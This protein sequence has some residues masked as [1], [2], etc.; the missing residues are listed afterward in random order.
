M[1]IHH[2]NCSTLCPLGGHFTDRISPG[3][4]AAH[5]VCHC[6]LIET[7]DGLVL[8]DTGLGIHDVAAPEERINPFLRAIL[9]PKLDVNETAIAQ[10]RA[11]GFNPQNVKHIILT[12]L[13]FDHSG[14]IEDFPDAQIHVLET[15]LRA[16]NDPK[17]IKARIRYQASR[18]AKIKNWNTYYAEGEKWFGFEAVRQLKGIPPEIIMIP[19]CGHSEGHA[20]VA[21]NTDKGW[22]LHA[23]DAYFFRGEI[24]HDYSCPSGLRGYQ[25]LIEANHKMRIL[26][27]IKL[28]D[29]AHDHHSEVRIFSSHDSVEFADLKNEP[30]RLLAG[31]PETFGNVLWMRQPTPERRPFH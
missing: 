20:G 13:D 28:R 2:L 17:G 6:L 7:S 31:S 27:L 19:L 9:R 14:G 8:V 21:I 23:G 4:V 26:N 1:R 16:A 24:N 10:I 3:L 11:L 29:L 15:E 30:P 22:L 25:K 5:M 12:H 18:L